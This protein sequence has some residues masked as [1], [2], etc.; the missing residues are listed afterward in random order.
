MS[1]FVNVSEAAKILGV[2]RTLVY[3]AIER[4]M[5]HP[6]PPSPLYDGRGPV[7]LQRSE[8]EELAN[9]RNTPESS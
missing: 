3:R 5:L 2:S 6:L 4:G 1:D 8:V 9:R 7:K